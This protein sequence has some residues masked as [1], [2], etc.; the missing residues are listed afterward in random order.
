MRKKFILGISLILFTISS[1]QVG[2][3]TT[4]PNGAT[5]L[6]INSNAK[7][8]LIPRLTD[9]E[10]NSSLADNDILT[11]PPAGVAN[12]NLRAGTLIYNTTIDRFEFWDGFLWRQLF[13]A[14]SSAAGNDGVV[15]VNSG[16]PLNERPVLT[17]SAANGT[18]APGQQV[19]YKTPLNFAPAPTTSWPETTVPYPGVTSNIYVEGPIA[20]SGSP[21]VDP[22]QRWIENEVP[23]QVHIWRLVVFARANAGSD[24]TIKAELRNPES[25][26]TVNSIGL[27]P[28]ASNFS[29]GNVVAFYFYTI[30]DQESLADGRG[31]QLFLS[32]DVNTTVT[33]ES[34]TRV[35]LFKD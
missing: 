18:Y 3:N 25:N 9:T 2:I 33:V 6:D 1:A 23:G 15:K 21:L 5:V 24:G 26:F 28:A 7:G 31:Y 20:P 17:L 4:N 19:I 35:S 13:V 16:G 27:I 11:I 34:F 14:T 29:P 30:A 8:V 12:A 32:A 22:D 10:R